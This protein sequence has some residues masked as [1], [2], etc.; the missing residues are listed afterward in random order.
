LTELL[1]KN[2]LKWNLEADTAFNTLKKAM[3]EVPLLGMPYFKKPLGR[4]MSAKG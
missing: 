1:K 4:L 2:A 3:T